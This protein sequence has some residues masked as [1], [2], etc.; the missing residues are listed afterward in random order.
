MITR[1]KVFVILFEYR[2]KD[3]NTNFLNRI[4]KGLIKNV[5]SICRVNGGD[6]DLLKNMRREKN[7]FSVSRVLSRDTAS[8]RITPT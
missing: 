4:P 8:K 2:P 7:I 3:V 5:L 1:D 6:N